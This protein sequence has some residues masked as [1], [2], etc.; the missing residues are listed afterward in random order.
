[1]SSLFHLPGVI[2]KLTSLRLTAATIT[3]VLTATDASQ[4]V[5]GIWLVNETGGAVNCLVD[6]FDGTTN[7]HIMN[8]P[9]AANS[10]STPLEQ[11]IRLYSGH[12]IKATAASGNA[13]TVNV[14]TVRSMRQV[15]AGK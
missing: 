9:V 5:V 6:W 7:N 8:V 2:E 14:L 15:D 13:I 1:M 12:K 11:M 3:D 10:M 4:T